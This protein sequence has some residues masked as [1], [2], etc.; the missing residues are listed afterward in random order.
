MKIVSITEAKNRLSALI[1]HVRGGE[2]VLIMDHGRP[3][4]RLES[5]VAIDEA[6]Q[7]RLSRLERAGIVRIATKKLGEDL[8]KTAPPRAR[9]NADVVRVL[10]EERREGR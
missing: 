2:I 5:A 8:I 1:D 4:A 3:V 10:L 7:G 9:K 6:G